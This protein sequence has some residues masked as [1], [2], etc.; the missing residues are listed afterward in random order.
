[1]HGWKD[2]YQDD[3]TVISINDKTV[4]VK[5]NRPIWG[6][7]I[8]FLE[9]YNPESNVTQY[10][11]AKEFD[12]LGCTESEGAGASNGIF[13]GGRVKSPLINRKRKYRRIFIRA[14]KGVKF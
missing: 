6:V 11:L 13:N 12:I 5:I 1:M 8:T 2:T 9:K 7:P 14:K 3:I 10:N 4:D